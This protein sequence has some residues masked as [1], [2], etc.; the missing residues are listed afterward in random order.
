MTDHH[1]RHCKYTSTIHAAVRR[2]R[3]SMHNT[4]YDGDHVDGV[5]QEKRNPNHSNSAI[6]TAS[7]CQLF[8]LTD[9]QSYNISC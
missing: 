6:N 9:E 3:V 8:R 5:I 7:K 4:G 2:L 1:R